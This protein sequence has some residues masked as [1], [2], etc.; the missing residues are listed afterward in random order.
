VWGSIIGGV[1][2]VLFMGPFG[3]IFGPF[4]GAV[5]GEL[6][7]KKPLDQAFQV[8]FGTIIGFLG[9]AVLKLSV[10]AIMIVWFFAVVL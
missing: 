3:L 7:Q 1:L 10:E 4:I 5:A 8:G 9:G 6:Y 2:G